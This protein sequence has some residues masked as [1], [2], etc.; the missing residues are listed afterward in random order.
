MSTRFLLRAAL[1]L[2][3]LA[4][5]SKRAE[6]SRHQWAEAEA[7]SFAYA[8]ELAL[9]TKGTC[10]SNVEQLKADRMLPSTASTVDPWGSPYTIRCAPEPVATSLGP[11][12]Q[13]GTADDIVKKTKRR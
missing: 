12:K 8:A 2:P 10:P 3:L 13:A 9:E 7:E 1:L 11:D 4:C 5:G 6:Q